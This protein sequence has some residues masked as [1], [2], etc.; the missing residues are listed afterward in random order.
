MEFEMS[1]KTNRRFWNSLSNAYQEMYG[2]AF[3]EKPLAW[4]VWSIPESDLNVLGQV[5]ERDVLN[6]D[7]ERH[8][9]R[10]RCVKGVREQSDWICQTSNWLT[11]AAGARVND[12]L[13]LRACCVGSK[14]AGGTHLE[15]QKG[16]LTTD[17]VTW[18]ASP[19]M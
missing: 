19:S 2:A 13:R 15:A 11:R 14:V 1:S 5:K 4:G 17:H 9:G 8:S 6:S 7:A 16:R 3:S 18:S 12:I 10:L